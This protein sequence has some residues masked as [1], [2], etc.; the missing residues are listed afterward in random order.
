MKYLLCLLIGCWVMLGIS[1]CDTEPVDDGV[2]S[3]FYFRAQI[4]G[5]ERLYEDEPSGPEGVGFYSDNPTQV[6]GNDSCS[7][8]YI[9]TFRN[10]TAGFA[11]IYIY[12]EKYYSG[13]CENESQAFRLLF[14]EGEK[15]FQASVNA[16]GVVLEYVDDGNT[17]WRSRPDSTN[18]FLVATSER[19]SDNANFGFARHKITGSTSAWLYAQDGDSLK[20]ENGE[21]SI[22]TVANLD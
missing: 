21:F 7:V 4:D 22:Y 20:L 12:F 14:R 16:P 18:T 10:L 9:T 6:L 15:S 11:G 3:E 17:V 1:G 2:L 13:L 5:E 19:M 8:S